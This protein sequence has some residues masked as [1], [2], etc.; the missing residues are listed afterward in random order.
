MNHQ[1][2]FRGSS[3]ALCLLLA[4]GCASAPPPE[5]PDLDVSVPSRWTASDTAAEAPE[6]PIEAWWTSFADPRLD[7]LITEALE[8]NRDLVAAAARVDAAVAQARIIGADLYPQI[9]AGFDPARSRRNFIGF[10][11]PGSE[12][13]VLSVTTSSFG[14]GLNIS[15]EADLWGR[16]SARKGA[17]LA[18]VEASRADLAAAQL[19]LAGQTAKTW[20]AVVEAYQQVKLAAATLASRRLSRERIERRYQLGIR[21]ALEL[22]FAMSNEAGAEASMALRRRQLDLAKRQLELL[23]SR[24]PDAELEQA[25]GELEL[26][27][28]PSGVPPG[29]PSELVI[30]RPDLVATERRLAAAGLRIKE[31]RA[32][33][34]PQLRLT[35]SAGT[36]S[37][38]VGDLLSLDFSVWSL[39][40]NLLQ[41]LYQGG[42]LRGGVQLSEA[43]YR[44]LAES[45]AQVILRAFGEV[46]STLAAEQFLAQ[47]ERALAVAAEQSVAAE[48]LSN[49]RYDAGLVNYLAVLEAQRNAFVAQSQHLTSR[50]QR[51]DARIDLYLALGGG[52]DASFVESTDSKKHDQPRKEPG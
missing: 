3:P 11:I 30:R 43:N 18:G 16:L 31:A 44:E 38:E 12:G 13:Q 52:F 14:A 8:R 49:Q 21:S 36:L 29:L 19:S 39:A 42:R 41:P 33:L 20:F 4:V 45:Y 1:S 17:S 6:R 7:T 23:L 27:D 37:N 5:P 22:R 35:G 9:G 2:L 40:A 46:E 50:R 15:W 47:Q 24:Y 51:L 26:P 32:S 48:R 34:Y 28:P 10:P 25:S